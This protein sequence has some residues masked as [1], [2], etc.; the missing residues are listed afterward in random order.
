[1][2]EMTPAMSQL[3]FPELKLILVQCAGED[4]SVSLEGDVLDVPFTDL[5][6]DSLAVLET[7]AVV[8]QRFGTSLRD[9]EVSGVETPREFLDLV[10][11]AMSKVF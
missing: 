1:M 6:Y 9:E 3:T 10:N 2:K 11:G 5:G 8:D 7:A 4:E